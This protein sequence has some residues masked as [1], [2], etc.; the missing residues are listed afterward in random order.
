MEMEGV[1]I[2]E[3]AKHI[4]SNQKR[5][6]IF[7]CANSSLLYIIP[8][9]ILRLNFTTLWHFYVVL[10]LDFIKEVKSIYVLCLGIEGKLARY[11]MIK[12]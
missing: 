11:I 3:E 4:S 12:V 6:K 2:N 7:D 10:W 5:N 1:Y 8:F 9:P